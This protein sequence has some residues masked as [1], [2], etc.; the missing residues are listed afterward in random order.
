MSF[1]NKQPRHLLRKRPAR[2]TKTKRCI[3]IHISPSH[4]RAVQVARSG[5]QFCIE[6]VF[7]A[8]TRRS[9]D[10]PPNLLKSL[11]TKQ[12]FDR[13][14]DIAVSMPHG[15]VFFR[16]FETD[17][18][19]LEQIRADGS[20]VMKH[21]LPIPPD[22]IIAQVCSFR[23]LPPEK[24]SVLVAA[25]SKTSLLERLSI[26]D[27][28]K[29]SPTLVETPVL[30]MYSTVV[31]NH[32][33]I[34]DGT[35]IIASICEPNLTLAVS[36]NN[37]ILI[38]RNIPIVPG[39][40]ADVDFDREQ[41]AELLANEVEITWR[42]R[43]GGEMDQDTT[44]YLAAGSYDADDLKAMLEANLNCKVTIVDP[45][46]RVKR[47]PQCNGDTA[48]WIAEG[49]ALR[50]LASDQT[51]GIN[52]LEA[53]SAK[54]QAQKNLRKELAKCAALIAA[55]AIVWLVGLFIRLSH[56]EAKNSQ[57]QNEIKEIFHR[58]LPEETNIV[59]P[60]VQLEQKLQSLKTDQT[61]FGSGTDVGPL[62]VLRI[63]TVRVP[64]EANIKI[65]DMLINA[66]A[67]RFTGTAQSSK[68][69]DNW[70]H[71][72]QEV[73]QFSTVDVQDIQ[74]SSESGLVHFTML[75][76]LTATEQK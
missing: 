76:S 15:A 63:V 62:E 43:F 38:V 57:M 54:P 68:S 14:A 29:M 74:R 60:L 73:P 61:L 34:I 32:P 7:I 53:G 50:V 22:E 56:L 52:F 4:L 27:E 44:I 9:T 58:T 19:G 2:K 48:L 72:L 59:N 39:T 1:D 64:A 25:A 13:R 66:K 37:K 41:V 18:A 10:S 35:V 40:P 16:S 55:I 71:L 49:L 70:R 65:E 28:A 45:Y 30:A 31:V 33:E 20:S 21:N 17:A 75:V 6:K 46:V 8:K 51:T 12:E 67:A 24:Y 47:S 11:V 69:V 42:K 36:Q 5:E 23:K 26:L 3:G